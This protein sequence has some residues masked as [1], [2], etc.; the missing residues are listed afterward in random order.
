MPFTFVV[1]AVGQSTSSATTSLVG[2]IESGAYCGPEFISTSQ[3]AGAPSTWIASHGLSSNGGALEWPVP[4][5]DNILVTLNVSAGWVAGQ[6]IQPGTRVYGLGNSSPS[7]TRES[8]EHLL[9]TPIAWASLLHETIVS[10]RFENPYE[11]F[12]LDQD[13]GVRFYEEELRSRWQ[14]GCRPFVRVRLAG[15]SHLEL[16]MSAQQDTLW[17]FDGQSRLRLGYHSGH[18]SH[19]SFR[20]AEAVQLHSLARDEADHAWHVLLAWISI[21][22]ADDPAFEAKT[23]ELVSYIPGNVN[24]AAVADALIEKCSYGGL[25]WRE[26]EDLGWINDGRYSQRNPDSLLSTLS[27]EEFRRLRDFFHR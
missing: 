18:F 23:R 8:I 5:G 22:D 16:E 3:T 11:L 15:A 12:G 1:D 20:S 24:T 13:E 26:H 7:A 4:A 17:L 9:D 2:R 21:W 14:K 10:E 27:P 19:P 6:Q 25:L